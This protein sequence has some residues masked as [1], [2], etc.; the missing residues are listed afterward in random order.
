M[1]KIEIR[2]FQ[3]RKALMQEHFNE[4]YM[5][6]EKFPN[7]TFKGSS[8]VPIDLTSQN[9]QEVILN[10]DL[11]VHGITQE[12]QIKATLTF[13]ENNTVRLVSNFNVKCVDHDIKIPK[14][15]WKNIAE[16]I[17]VSVNAEYKIL[18]K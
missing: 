17:A 3:F 1:F 2:S 8:N 6:S 10:G 18:S 7:A 13:N 5:E 16:I 9:N 4:N 11:T 15:V 12:R 14:I